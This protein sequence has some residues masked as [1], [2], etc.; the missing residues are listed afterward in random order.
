M[1]KGKSKKE[2]EKGEEDD[3]KYLK[4]TSFQVICAETC[5]ATCVATVVAET[6]VI[7]ETLY[8]EICAERN[9]EKGS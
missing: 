7:A 9:S 8:L 5:V 4:E 2:K 1:V 6:G 3:Y